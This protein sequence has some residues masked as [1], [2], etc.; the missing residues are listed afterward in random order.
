[1]SRIISAHKVSEIISNISKDI[2]PEEVMAD[3]IQMTEEQAGKMMFDC[4]DFEQGWEK[5]KSNLRKKG[6]IIK[7]ELQQKVEEAERMWDTKTY[8]TP[9]EHIQREAIQNLKQSHPEFKE[10]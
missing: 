3:K 4:F 2:K 8:W 1:M 7:S 10:K 9:L 6:Y 5:T